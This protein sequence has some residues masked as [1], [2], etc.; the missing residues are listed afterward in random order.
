MITYLSLLINTLVPLKLQ[1]IYWSLVEKHFLNKRDISQLYN[2]TLTK[3]NEKGMNGNALTTS[4]ML[5][6]LFEEH[7]ESTEELQQIIIALLETLDSFKHSLDSNNTEADNSNKNNNLN[8]S[9]NSVDQQSVNICPV[10]F[11]NS[12]G[13]TLLHYAASFGY[14]KLCEWLIFRAKADVNVQN[15][16]GNTPLHN[17]ST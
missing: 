15:L 13:D 6:A 7:T 9:L 16:E 3:M 4:D 8:H 11:R 5:L 12:E 17:A 2:N 14:Y 10:T 1:H